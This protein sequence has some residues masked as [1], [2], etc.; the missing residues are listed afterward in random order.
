MCVCVCETEQNDGKSYTLAFFYYYFSPVSN[1]N[2]VENKRL[3]KLPAPPLRGGNRVLDG[4]RNANGFSDERVST[5][6]AYLLGVVGASAP[7][8]E[9]QNNF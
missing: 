5:L 6:G 2:T 4:V 3:K 9:F 7:P 8:P 1:V